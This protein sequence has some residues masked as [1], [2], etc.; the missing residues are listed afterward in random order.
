M[1]FNDFLVIYLAFGAP[2]AVHYFLQ[3]RR[4]T[5]DLR[6]LWLKTILNFF[7]WLPLLYRF[8]QNNQT[9][10]NSF[11]KIFSKKSLSD[12]ITEENLRVIQKR[13]EKIVPED[14]TLLSIFE[15]REVFERY[16]GLTLACQN[17]TDIA[18]AARNKIFQIAGHNNSEIAEI[19]LKRRNRK[20]L[21]RHQTQA[22][23]D[24]LNVIADL[25]KHHSETEKLR[26]TAFGLSV[27][28]GDVIAQT[29]LKEMLEQKSQSA[30][31]SRVK[32]ARNDLWKPEPQLLPDSKQTH[33]KSLTTA[34]QT[35]TATNSRGKD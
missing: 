34:A 6:Q 4:R 12:S 28:L 18:Q 17:E 16:A 19:C 21:L 1:T 9:L 27:L 24:F 35:A 33:L 8:L 23:K 31:A 5:S 13:L 14:E 20:R 29:A 15:V 26:E 22:R 10:K 7:F 32:N 30:A 3:Q 2:L 11:G 25:L